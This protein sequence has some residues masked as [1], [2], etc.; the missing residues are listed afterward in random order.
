MSNLIREIE[1]ELQADKL[2]AL[3]Q[4]F[5]TP[6]LV[7]AGVLVAGTAGFTVW[8]SHEATVHQQQT[9]SLITALDQKDMNDAFSKIPDAQKSS[10]EPLLAASTMAKKDITKAIGIYDVASKDKSLPRIVR[11][12]ATLDKLW[13]QLRDTKTIKVDEAMNELKDL[14]DARQANFLAEANFLSGFL[15][16]N[17]Q[18]NNPDAKKFYN[19]V[20]YDETAPD[21]LKS[22]AQSLLMVMP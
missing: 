4:K 7:G 10:I 11:D 18:N 17:I 21:S 12:R 14:R 15:A 16:Q 8:N 13:L 9:A 19:A 3:W 5:Q 1:D 6:I 20:I 2:A 22:R